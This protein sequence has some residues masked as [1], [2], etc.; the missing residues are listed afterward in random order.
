V[1]PL[2]GGVGQLA[3][4][5]PAV[6]DAGGVL[7]AEEQ[8][9]AARH[10]DGIVGQH[11]VGLGLVRAGHQLEH[12]AA[13]VDV[14]LQRVEELDVLGRPVG[15]L[16]VGQDLADEQVALPQRAL[17]SGPFALPLALAAALGLGVAGAGREQQAA[18]GDDDPEQGG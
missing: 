17:G 3:E 7:G 9:A 14:G 5:L 12:A 2:A 1:G 4:G 10:D 13:Q 18:G 6:V 16:R 15:A 11:R 8:K